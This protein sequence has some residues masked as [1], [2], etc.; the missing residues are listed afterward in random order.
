MCRSEQEFTVCNSPDVAA[1]VL[2]RL[3]SAWRH[4]CQAVKPPG[5]PLDDTV[6]CSYLVE[7]VKSA[8]SPANVGFAQNRLAATGRQRPKSYPDCGRSRQ[9]PLVGDTFG[10]SRPS[11][12][13]DVDGLSVRNRREG[14]IRR[15]WANANYRPRSGRTAASEAD[16]HDPRFASS[17]SSISSSQPSSL[18]AGTDAA[19]AWGRMSFRGWEQPDA[20]RRVNNVAARTP[21]LRL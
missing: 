12:V 15:V 14:A 4:R 1:G 10:S 9:R 2:L 5:D 3:R 17:R 18:T 20:L 19:S 8:S 11:A 13:F 16:V 7:S 6:H 21:A